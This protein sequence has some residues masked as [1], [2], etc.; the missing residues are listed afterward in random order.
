MIGPDGRITLPLAGNIPVANLTRSDAQKAII[1]ALK[2]KHKSE[3]QAVSVTASTGM[4]ASNIGGALRQSETQSC[5]F[6]F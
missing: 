1:T 5:F 4:A 2:K 3:P 6:F